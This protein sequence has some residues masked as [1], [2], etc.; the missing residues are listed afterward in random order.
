LDVFSN[1]E[2]NNE[3]KKLFSNNKKIKSDFHG[4]RDYFYLIRGV[5]NYLNETNENPVK[6]IEKYIERNFGGI[7]IE[8]DFNTNYEFIS[9]DFKHKEFLKEIEKKE[10]ITS[11]ELFKEVYNN[12]CQTKEMNDYKIKE[13]DISN[14]NIL[15]NIIDNIKDI[16]SRYLLLEIKPSLGTLI[17]NKI[18]K[19]IKDK[20]IMFHD[21][22][23]FYDDNNNE[24]Q[25][26]KINEIQDHAGKGDKIILQNLN[27]IYPF[28]YDLFN[29][30]YIIKDGKKYSR[31]CHGNF[32]DQ[33]T[34]INDE[35]RVI[36]MVDKSFIDKVAPPFLNRFEKMII[37]FNKLLDENQKIIAKS[38][39]YELQIMEQKNY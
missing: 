2:T 37:S 36:I 29:M 19:E 8:L 6:I 17:K 31:I 12:H 38:I 9:N 25:F 27:Q 39:L 7:E 1:F 3:Y 23:P 26:H 14:Y 28:L 34:Y 13:E 20:K 30:N 32:S 22:S 16:R 10:K 24:Y 5:A 18:Q 15:N 35:F 21:G 33:L 4:N 11:V